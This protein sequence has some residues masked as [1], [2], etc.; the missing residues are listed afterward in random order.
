MNDIEFDFNTDDSV[1]ISN[2]SGNIDEEISLDESGIVVESI[3]LKNG[4]ATGNEALRILDNSKT[5]DE[6][7]DQLLEVS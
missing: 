4:I 5:R 2:K 7:I 1:F 3:S 6:F